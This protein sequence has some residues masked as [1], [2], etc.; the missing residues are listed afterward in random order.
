MP[1]TFTWDAAH[2]GSTADWTTP[3]NWDQNS[4]YPGNTGDEDAIV[5]I[6]SGMERCYVNA[7]LTIGELTVSGNHNGGS[8]GTWD[9]KQQNT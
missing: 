2:A 3:A 9:V 7:A 6:P 1:T 5:I 4:S 8:A